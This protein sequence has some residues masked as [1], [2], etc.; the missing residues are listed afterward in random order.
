MDK[1]NTVGFCNKTK[2]RYADVVS[3]DKDMKMVGSII[4]V[5]DAHSKYAFMVGQNKARL[6]PVQNV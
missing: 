4:L 6:H 2:L 1:K 5:R 3:G